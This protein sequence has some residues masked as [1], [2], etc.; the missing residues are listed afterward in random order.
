MRILMVEDEKYM[1]EAVAAVLRKNHYAVDL[2][3][4]GESGLYSAL[5]GIYD[6]IIL[7][8]MLPEVDGL[9]ILREIR[10]EGIDTPVI[11]LTARDQLKD[12]INGLDMGADDYLA[13]PFHADEL[14][15]RLRA[16]GRRRGDLNDGG[17]L[18]FGDISLNPHT[19]TA[20][21]NQQ[22]AKLTLK[23]SQLLELLIQRPNFITSKELIIDKLWGYESDIEGARVE[24]Q[25]S[26]LRRKI[27]SLSKSI[28]IVTIRGIGYRLES[29]EELGQKSAP[30]Q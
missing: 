22:K 19:L 25:V 5:S 27:A 11:L 15:A 14:L 2:E 12:K 8:I 24:N 1:A 18:S 16:L 26:L 10:A 7:D 21:S 9:T 6:I 4:S 20:Y 29:T 13:K 30:K 23:E 3:L 28:Q 17:L